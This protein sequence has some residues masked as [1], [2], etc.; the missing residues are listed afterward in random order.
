MFNDFLNVCYQ[1]RPKLAEEQQAVVEVGVDQGLVVAFL[2]V[3]GVV[4]VAAAAVAV[5]VH[6]EDSLADAAAEDLGVVLA[7]DTSQGRNATIFKFMG[8]S[9]GAC[10]LY[11]VC[12]PT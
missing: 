3:V 5:E 6:E 11:V 2:E 10:S 12:C 7:V 9:P 1:K 4:V 8:F